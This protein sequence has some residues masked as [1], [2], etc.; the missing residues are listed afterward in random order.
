MVLFLDCDTGLVE[1][2]NIIKITQNIH[3]AK[4]MLNVPNGKLFS[5][6]LRIFYESLT[7]IQN[8]RKDISAS[9]KDN[10]CNRL[11]CDEKSVFFIYFYDFVILFFI[12][13]TCIDLQMHI[14]L[15]QKKKKKHLLNE[16]ESK[17][18]K[19]QRVK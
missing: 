15:L 13:W 10:W 18:V 16:T 1:M 19:I 6:D 12:L 4:C 14:L 3:N 11:I 7:S 8:N 5:I 17:H 9:K 2:D